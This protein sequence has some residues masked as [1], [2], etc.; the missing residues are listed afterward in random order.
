MDGPF[1]GV[2]GATKRA[3]HCTEG[4]HDP[5]TGLASSVHLLLGHTHEIETPLSW[6]LPYYSAGSHAHAGNTTHLGSA[7][8]QCR[9][10][11]WNSMRPMLRKVSEPVWTWNRLLLR[12]LYVQDQED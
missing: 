3:V 12:G 2:K 7:M 10:M 4:R 6:S 9:V 11:R 8:L 5:V 1:P